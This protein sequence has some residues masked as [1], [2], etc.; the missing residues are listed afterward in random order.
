M[1]RI[2]ADKEMDVANAFAPDCT[3]IPR[4]YFLSPRGEGTFQASWSMSREQFERMSDDLHDGD[5]V[6]V[7]GHPVAASEGRVADV[8]PTE[9]ARII[10]RRLYTDRALNYGRA[11][12]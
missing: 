10:R 8:N 3:Y 9:Y 2:D 11:Q 1:I 4:T 12:K 6:I 5:M 7:Y